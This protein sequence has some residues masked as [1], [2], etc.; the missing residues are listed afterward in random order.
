MIKALLRMFGKANQ[1]HPAKKPAP[2]PG[3]KPQKPGS[4]FRAVSIASGGVC[5]AAAKSAA[6]AQHLMRKAPRLPLEQC[7]MP[8]NCS[9][10][11]RKA[12][13]R[14][15]CDR[16]LFGGLATNRWFNGPNVRKQQ[17]RRSTKV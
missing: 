15:D 12:S 2:T 3:L 13:D 8:A 11:Y 14:R 16:R 17:A 7:T 6:G 10:K 5:C 9:C 1:A 4:D